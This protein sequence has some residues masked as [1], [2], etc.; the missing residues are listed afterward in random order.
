[1]AFK[2]RERFREAT[3]GHI[4]IAIANE[5]VVEAS[6]GRWDWSSDESIGSDDSEFDE[7]EQRFRAAMAAMYE[8]EGT[9]LA[10]VESMIGRISL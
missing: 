10:E 4:G 5:P 3:F 7:E 6:Q 8:Q 2:D 1:L 9:S